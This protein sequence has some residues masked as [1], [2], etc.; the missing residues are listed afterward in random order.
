[1][2][3]FGY[4]ATRTRQGKNDRCRGIRGQLEYGVAFVSL[5]LQVSGNIMGQERKESS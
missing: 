5:Q 3:G 4:R 2:T 1:M